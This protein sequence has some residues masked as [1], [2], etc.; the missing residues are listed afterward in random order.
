MS[1]EKTTGTE[2]YQKPTIEFI[3]ME[4]EGCI[5]AGSGSGGNFEPGGGWGN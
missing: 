5:L 4:L 1:T 2:V 3:E